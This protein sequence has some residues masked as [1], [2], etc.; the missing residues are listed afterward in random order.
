MNP[1]LMESKVAVVY[2]AGAGIGR[3]RARLLAR[4]GASVVLADKMLAAAEETAASIRHEGGSVLVV[5]CDV[6]SEEQVRAVVDTTVATFGRL[7]VAVNNVGSALDAVRLPEVTAEQWDWLQR[8]NLRSAFLGMK[9]EIPAMLAS[10]GGAIVNTASAGGLVGQPLMGAYNATKFGVVG[11]TKSTA[12][13]YAKENIRINAVCP[14]AIMSHGMR[15]ALD[16]DPHFA[17]GYLAGMPIGRFLEPAEVA[18]VITWLCSDAAAVV[19]GAAIAADGAM[20]AD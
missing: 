11:L 15:A 14:G 1:W 17:D 3:E 16:A 6:E 8:I 20:S 12:L 7:D 13:D 9:Y 5:E 19:T 10:G 2:G 4:R 18:E